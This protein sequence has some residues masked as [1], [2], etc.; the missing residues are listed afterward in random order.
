ML[1]LKEIVNVNL[2]TLTLSMCL[3]PIVIT[4]RSRL[5]KNSS[6]DVRV[7]GDKHSVLVQCGKCDE[8]LRKY[9]N[10]WM[11]RNM[12][13]FRETKFAVFFTLTYRNDSV[14]YRFDEDSGEM[15][16]T[17]CKS[18]VASFLKRF[19][20]WRR[21]QGLSTDFKYFITS[22]YGPTTLRPHLHGLLHGIRL[23]DFQRFVSCWNREYGFTMQRE[24]FGYDFK[25]AIVSARYTAKYCAKGQ[26]E[27]PLVALCKVEPTFHL[28]SKGL[29]L[30]Y[31]TENVKSYHL[32]LDFNGPR[33]I[34][35]KYSDAYLAQI[36]ARMS[37]PLGSSCYSLP[38]YYREKIFAKRKG[39]QAAYSD[40]V[41]KK[42]LDEYEG[43]LVKIQTD[44]PDRT[45]FQASIV[46]Y[47][48]TLSDENQRA[49]VA[50][51]SI[52]KHLKH[53]KI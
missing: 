53:S 5:N 6:G 41:C 22:E 14:P 40:F 42:F 4:Y 28:I 37:V 8:C 7:Y 12:M 32:A 30:C 33:R 34:N 15:Y 51:D 31:L 29:G 1:Y 18:Q 16:L 35:G 27:N 13:Q 23:Y 11:F 36:F 19:R 49:L 39:L 2:N 24:V 3:H 25:N 26:A 38:R 50:C 45:R 46:L 43:K 20:E 21:K 17:V 48:Q 10:S 9:Q 44:K 52:F 47:N